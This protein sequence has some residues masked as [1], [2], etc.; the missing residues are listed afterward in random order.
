MGL[1]FSRDVGAAE[2][3]RGVNRPSLRCLRSWC[4][5][6]LLPVKRESS[7]LPEAKQSIPKWEGECHCTTG[8]ITLHISLHNDRYQNTQ[9][10]LQKDSLSIRMTKYSVIYLVGAI[11]WPDQKV[12]RNA[13]LS[14]RQQLS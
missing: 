5:S 1:G 14:L 12:K 7:L 4:S 11:V 8:D 2:R 6:M 3:E 9:L 10:A 13:T